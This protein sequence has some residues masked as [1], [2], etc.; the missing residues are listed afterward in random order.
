MLSLKR[1]LFGILWFCVL[2]A[3]IFSIAGVVLSVHLHHAGHDPRQT[4]AIMLS[5]FM[6]DRLNLILL[7]L[8]IGVVIASVKGWL[9]G[10]RPEEKLGDAC[11]GA[12][13]C[14]F[15]DALALVVY[16]V[17]IQT[18]LGFVQGALCEIIGQPR[19]AQLPAAHCTLAA[20]S[21]IL[22]TLFA[23]KVSKAPAAGILGFARVHALLLPLCVLLV[24]GDALVESEIDNMQRG[25]F[26]YPDVLQQIMAGMLNEGLLSVFL[27]VVIAPL[28]EEIVFRGI[29]LKSFL[30]KYSP[31]RAIALSSI[32]FSLAHMDPMQIVSALGFGIL[33]GWLYFETENL[34]LCILVHSS[35]NF[36]NYLVYH[37]SIPVHISGFSALAAA[38]Y[39]FQPVWIDFLGVL[40][41]GIG[42]AGI[43]MVAKRKWTAAESK[44]P[45]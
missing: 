26:S 18:G 7:P 11:P 13:F 22:L 31:G 24:A 44:D 45:L 30:R 3:G 15:S 14:G 5:N 4:V 27:L 37:D 41:L 17:L 23:L 34:W 19:I 21:S 6:A 38:K 39:Q 32:A 20:L 28:A 1:P 16:L 8:F 9:P 29:I 12:P 43:R 25:L 40:L 36:L 35:H 10:T 42:I 2:S 33:L